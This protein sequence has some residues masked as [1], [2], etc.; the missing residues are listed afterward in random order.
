VR[1]RK[2]ASQYEISEIHLTQFSTVANR[3]WGK[4]GKLGQE[5]RASSFKKAREVPLSFLDEQ[6]RI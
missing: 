2:I 3:R 1:R 6:G 4:V 5:G